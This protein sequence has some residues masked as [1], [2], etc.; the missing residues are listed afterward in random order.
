M[1][2]DLPVDYPLQQHP[3][4]TFPPAAAA[5][6]LRPPAEPRSGRWVIKRALIG[7]TLLATFAIGGALLLHASIEPDPTSVSNE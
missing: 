5:P 2:G 7:L 4:T 3:H 6:M 1:H